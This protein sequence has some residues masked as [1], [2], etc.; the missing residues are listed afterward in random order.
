L[1]NSWRSIARPTRS[2]PDFRSWQITKIFCNAKLRRYRGMA[3]IDQGASHS[4]W[5]KQPAGNRLAV[6]VLWRHRWRCGCPLTLSIGLSAC[7]QRL[8]EHDVGVSLGP[9]RK[10]SHAREAGLL[11]QSWR[12]EVIARHPDPPHAATSA[13]R[14]IPAVRQTARAAQAH[15]VMESGLAA[16]CSKRGKLGGNSPLPDLPIR[17][18]LSAISAWPHA[19]FSQRATW[20]PCAAVRQRSIALIT[21]D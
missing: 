15:F 5:L 11:I 9:S 7:D 8:A 2:R 13:M 17:Q 6:P 4:I 21:F 18:E 1:S 3:D 12:L 16:T 10:L 20:P 19:A 14:H